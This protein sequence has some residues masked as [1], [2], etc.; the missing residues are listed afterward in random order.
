MVKIL[1]SN[2]AKAD[3]RQVSENATQLDAEERTLLLSLIEDFRDLFDG[4]LGDWST[5]PVDL[6]LK[7][8]SKPL[9]SRYYPVSIINKETF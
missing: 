4:I 1:D 3:P 5:E 8:D 7:P 6:E 2:Y 9:N